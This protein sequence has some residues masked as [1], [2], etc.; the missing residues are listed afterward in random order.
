MTST[1][2]YADGTGDTRLEWNKDVPAEVDAARETFARLHGENKYLAYKTRRDGS[3]GEVIR[4]FDPN[5]ERIVM[6]PQ[7]QG[8]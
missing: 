1:L 3:R 6:V 5:A 8:G 4:S 2:Q 7:T